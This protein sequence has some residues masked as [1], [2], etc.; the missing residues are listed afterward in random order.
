MTRVKAKKRDDHES[1][2][3]GRGLGLEERALCV[4]TR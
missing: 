4:L 3:G 1:V 2:S